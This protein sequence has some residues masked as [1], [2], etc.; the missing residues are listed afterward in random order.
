M[1]A[2][3]RLTALFFVCLGWS[4]QAQVLAD[5]SEVAAY[6]EAEAAM[7]LLE[8]N[9]N[10]IP[11]RGLESLRVAYFS[12]NMEATS[13]LLRY[14]RKYTQVAEWY[15]VAGA[16]NLHLP[17]ADLLIV[18][19]DPDAESAGN[20]SAL[21]EDSLLQP[22]RKIVVWLGA[23]AQLANA[24]QW[25]SMDGLLVSPGPEPFASSLAAQALFGAV[26]IGGKLAAG[27][28]EKYPAGSG[29]ETISIERLGYAPPGAVGMDA[30]LLEDS[31]RAIVEEGLRAE[32]YPGA[33]VLVAKDGKVIY[34]RTFGTWTYD[35]KRPVEET[36]LYDFASVTKV[37][38]ALPAVMKLYGEGKFDLDAPLEKYVSEMA[39]SNKADATYRSIMAHNARF[40][41]YITYWLGTLRGN[42]K[43]PW[44]KNWNSSRINDYRFRARTF[45]RD[46]SAR[47]PTK[48]ADDLWLHRDFKKKIYKNIRKSPLNEKPGYVYSGLLFLMLPDIVSDMT[49]TDY[50]TYLKQTFYHRLGAYTMT[51]NPLRHFPKSRIVPTENDTFFSMMQIHGRVHDEAAAVMGGVSS[52]AGLFASANDLAKL[53]Q[54]YMN[55]GTYGGERYI[56]E[57]AVEEFTR[58]QYC[59]EGNRRGLGFDKPLIEYNEKASSVAKDASPASFGHSGYTGTFVWADPEHNLLY[60]FFSNRVYPTRANT[61]LYQLGI[62][63]RIH[64][65][66]YDAM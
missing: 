14:L 2:K 25:P 65:A 21:Q 45:Q 60:I 4:V 15:P 33:Q 52:N 10:L 12:N 48:V 66:L 26:G 31:I 32:A 1:V 8:N 49:N 36:D 38:G 40:L 61:K 9:E 34:H 57:K 24:G 43:Y 27:I 37:T 13:E 50:E 51:Y 56:A 3:I 55:K 30:Q 53:F 20:W 42:S 6:R 54:M 59:E 18:G 47:F 22:I 46:S 23:P 41:P 44:Q 7:V 35:R 58:C 28:S 64:Q 19:V 39:G 5:Q 16:E 62:R 17:E 11:L 63:P 29:L